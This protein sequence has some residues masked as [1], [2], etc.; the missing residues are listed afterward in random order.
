MQRDGA[1]GDGGGGLVGGTEG[2]SQA[3]LGRVGDTAA[4]TRRGD[5]GSHPS[6]QR[7]NC[8]YEEGDGCR[9]AEFAEEPEEKEGKDNQGEAGDLL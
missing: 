9:G 2:G 5:D 1:E 6:G 3:K 7:D 8:A 4:Q